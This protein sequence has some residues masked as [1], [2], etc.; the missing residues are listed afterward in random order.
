M[1]GGGGHCGAAEVEAGSL[2]AEGGAVSVTE[3]EFAEVSVAAGRSG[4]ARGAFAAQVTL[5]AVRTPR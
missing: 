4:L 2:A 1:A 5:A 3:E